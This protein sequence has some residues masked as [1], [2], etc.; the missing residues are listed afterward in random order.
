MTNWIGLR[1]FW[2]R[3]VVD[4][5]GEPGEELNL[6]QLEARVR[7]GVLAPRAWLRHRWTQ[8]YALAG[9]VLYQHGRATEEELDEWIPKPKLATAA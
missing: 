1:D 4:L 5:A 2:G 7:E 8:H 9:E 6:E 3:W